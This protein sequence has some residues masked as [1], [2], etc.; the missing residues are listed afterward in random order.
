MTMS[1]EWSL[2]TKK[3]ADPWALTSL[4]SMREPQE[5]QGHRVAVV[6]DGAAAAAARRAG[7]GRVAA[8]PDGAVVREEAVDD[9]PRHADAADGRR[10]WSTCCRSPRLRR[11]CSR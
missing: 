1:P 4:C 9:R 2:V 11:T 6:V 7:L 3:I 5:G 10:R 8:V